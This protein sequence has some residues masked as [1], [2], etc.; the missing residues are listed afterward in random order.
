VIDGIFN[1]DIVSVKGELCLFGGRNGPGYFI[2]QDFDTSL[3]F[4]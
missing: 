3:I 1:E 4:I 2:N